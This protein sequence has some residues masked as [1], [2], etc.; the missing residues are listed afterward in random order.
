M[1]P[2]EPWFSNPLICE[3]WRS[4]TLQWNTPP[5]YA[6]F[7]APMNTSFFDKA[8]LAPNMSFSTVLSESNSTGLF[9]SIFSLDLSQKLLSTFMNSNVKDIRTKY[10]V[11]PIFMQQQYLSL[12]VKDFVYAQT[13]SNHT[14]N[15]I[16]L[17]IPKHIFCE[18]ILFSRHLA[19]S[20]G[21]FLF[22]P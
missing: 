11:T 9:T 22:R 10:F 3:H 15:V 6:C 20:G 17:L 18:R 4:I 19:V 1:R 14:R 5:L 13:S 12:N 2:Y 7:G 21:K 8:I 16:I